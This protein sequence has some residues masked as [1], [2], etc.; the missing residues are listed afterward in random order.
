MPLGRRTAARSDPLIPCGHYEVKK[1]VAHRQVGA[2]RESKLQF[3]DG[4][5]HWVRESDCDN[6]VK[7]L[8]NYCNREGIEQT[9]LPQPSAGAS[10]QRE[11]TTENW[12]TAAEVIKKA[13]IYG[14][15]VG[16]QL[17]IFVENKPWDS[18][19]LEQVGQ[20]FFV[21]LYIHERN[22]AMVAD[23]LNSLP[24]DRAAMEMIKE[25]FAPAEVKVVRFKG[26][27]RDDRCGSAVVAIILE[28]QKTYDRGEIPVELVPEKVT[29]QR[30]ER[31][32]HKVL[33]TSW[34][35]I[36]E[37]RIGAGCPRCGKTFRNA[38]NRA[39]LNLYKC[40]PE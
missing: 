12:V 4:S 19:Y 7:R 1:V 3:V 26:Q 20:H 6:C 31:A 29:Y 25:D 18:I 2:R 21:V 15:N 35:L 10:G 34:T 27:N 9:G 28:F 8:M 13:S 39:I 24:E 36:Q 16:I 30:V 23:G 14:K 32:L 5:E 37:Q 11:P 17:Y 40:E 22:L 38:K 33:I